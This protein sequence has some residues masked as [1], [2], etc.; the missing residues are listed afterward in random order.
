M[1]LKGD[2]YGTNNT[3]A[4][5]TLTSNSNSAGSGEMK[6]KSKLAQNLSNKI[7]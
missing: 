7:I 4:K 3:A 5:N 6:K 2:N 1:T